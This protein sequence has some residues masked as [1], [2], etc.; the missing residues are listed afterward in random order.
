[1][2][3]AITGGI[4]A[5]KSYV[6][7]LLKDMGYEVLDTDEIARKLMAPGTGL[8]AR[9][10]EAFEGQITDQEGHLDR[11]ALLKMILHNPEAREKLNQESP[12]LASLVS[13]SSLATTEVQSLLPA[14]EALI[15]FYFND[16]ELIAFVL[17][18]NGL[19]AIRLDSTELLD[20]VRKF[21]KSLENAETRDFQPVARRLHDQL[22]LPLIGEF[23]MKKLIVVAH[24]PLHYLPFAALHDGQS[25]LI[26][27]YSLRLLPSASVLKYL[28]AATLTKQGSLLAFGNPDLG[29]PKYDLDFAQAE[30][31]AV[32]KN[33]PQS[34]VLL[35]KEANESAFRQYGGEF[36]YLHF[37]THGQFNADAPLQSAVLLARD[38]SG[39]GRL[40]VD[41]LYS[42]QLD[43]DLVTL[44][45][46]ETGLGKIASGDDVVGLTRGFLYAGAA[47][48]VAS[49][50]QVDDEA[51]SLLMTRFYDN[52][53][54]TDKRE[55]LRLA[56]LET[57]KK[58]AHP[59]YW[60][61]FQL[62]GNAQ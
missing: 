17:T 52:L 47:S 13:V 35:R 9:V 46:C 61:A 55:A 33:R 62:T 49:L 57:R 8:E 20:N 45:A 26:D 31:I 32:T 11:A 12:Q 18:K 1:M 21:R 34:K 25:Y 44:S 29:N 51:T 7:K 43:A 22:V 30:A 60:A 24:G 3:I 5:G 42:I 28:R 37:A 16:P 53:R 50:W 48:I 58:F 10:L 39:D 59:Y 14:D 56:Q 4:G 19:N 54:Q 2:K 6:G 27:R 40:T 36:R 23:T 15:E 38:A 41:K